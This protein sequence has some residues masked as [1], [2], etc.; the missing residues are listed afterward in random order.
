LL[1]TRNEADIDDIL[2]D[3]KS[4]LQLVFVSTIGEVID[5]ALEVLVANPPPPPL[6]PESS[7]GSRLPEPEPLAVKGK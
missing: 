6:K 7:T 1:P 4:D 3:V 5:A 2:D